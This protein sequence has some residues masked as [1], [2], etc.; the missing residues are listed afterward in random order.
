MATYVGKEGCLI[1]GFQDTADRCD[2]GTSSVV[3]WLLFVYTE[4]IGNARHAQSAVLAGRMDIYVK[5]RD[6]HGKR[7]NKLLFCDGSSDWRKR[8]VLFEYE[9]AD[10]IVSGYAQQ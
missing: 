4:I 3:V 10:H 9:C 5:V 8:H 1:F 7:H 2:C 6:F